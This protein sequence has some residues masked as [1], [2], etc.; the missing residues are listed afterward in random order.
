MKPN[1]IQTVDPNRKGSTSGNSIWY[2]LPPSIL[3]VVFDDA[4]STQVLGSFNSGL[5]NVG[6]WDKANGIYK[7]H[8]SS[9]FFVLAASQFNIVNMTTFIKNNGSISSILEK[10]RGAG[11]LVIKKHL[12]SLAKAM[13]ENISVVQPHEF[14][15]LNY[16]E[17]LSRHFTTSPGWLFIREGV[18]DY[19]GTIRV[20]SVPTQLATE[21][22]PASHS[23]QVN[24]E[25]SKVRSQ[26]YNGAHRLKKAADMLAVLYEDDKPNIEYV[27]NV[28]P[29]N[30]AHPLSRNMENNQG[31]I[32]VIEDG[33]TKVAPTV[34]MGQDVF[35]NNANSI[36]DG[37][38]QKTTIEGPYT[39]NVHPSHPSSSF[40]PHADW[41]SA[42]FVFPK[43]LIRDPKTAATIIAIALLTSEGTESTKYIENYNRVDSV[44]DNEDLQ[45]NIGL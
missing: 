5:G 12:D 35:I 41:L 6:E 2:P 37:S 19:P 23:S 29:E 4:I 44:I 3:E 39:R 24:K 34:S 8:R 18:T 27:T 14:N 31:L 30:L 26:N 16:N 38:I 28:V 25:L 40:Y 42:L 20:K 32:T 43:S 11:P 7:H 22:I 36:Q 33:N 13:G 1:T 21:D 10:T 17:M 9:L 45:T 15:S